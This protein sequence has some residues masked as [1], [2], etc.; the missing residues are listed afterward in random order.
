MRTNSDLKYTCK[1]TFQKWFILIPIQKYS[2]LWNDPLSTK[3][4]H[5]SHRLSSFLSNLWPHCV[6]IVTHKQPHS[7]VKQTALGTKRVVTYKLIQ[8]V[9][10]WLLH[11]SC[12]LTVN[13]I[14]I[15]PFDYIRCVSIHGLG[16][17]V[18][19]RLVTYQYASPTVMSL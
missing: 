16:M 2:I 11:L 7:N 6:T 14:L 18:L 15:L 13:K 17:I 4:L 9:I 12:H 10:F 19:S 5:L 3:N 1:F 8:N